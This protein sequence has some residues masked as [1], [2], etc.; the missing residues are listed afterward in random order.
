MINIAFILIDNMLATSMTWPAEM[1]YAA[2]QYNRNI[3]ISITTI[4]QSKK[5]ETQSSLSLY[6]DT[7]LSENDD[8]YDF[9]FLP[10]LWRNPKPLIKRSASLINWLSKQ[11]L[12]GAN[13]SAVGTGCCLLAETGL[14]NNKPATTHWFFFEQFAK[15]YPLVNLKR[16]HFI[17][18]ADRL[19]CAA[20]I[21][22][23]ADLT[24]HHV[25]TIFGQET[26]QHIERHF[27]HEIR[28]SYENRAYF[29]YQNNN[30]AD[31]LI[32]EVQHWLQE[33]YAE[34]I[35]IEALAKK[36]DISER[37]FSRRFKKATHQTPSAYLMT[38]RIN[39]AIDLLQK[40]N[41]SIH[42]IAYQIG[43]SDISYFSA[44]F[45]KQLSVTP[46]EYR[47]TVRAKLFSH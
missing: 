46:S 5:I 47:K 41:L 32:S 29:E 4:A 39:M 44:L 1:L 14:L 9:I 38:V 25:D 11:Y 22:S 16:Q 30:H 2:K 3:P 34:N 12:L 21:N 42:E 40:T 20:S 43:F 27:S 37:H 6:A 10:A 19:F 8:T 36:Y 7:I 18:K 17:T 45:K 13:I 31:E 23:L 15:T 33:N 28:Q 24:V 26:A 35:S